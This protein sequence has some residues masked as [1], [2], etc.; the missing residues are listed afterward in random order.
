MLTDE[1]LPEGLV[2]GCEAVGRGGSGLFSVE[3]GA[4]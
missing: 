2:C 4:H 3:D 1:M